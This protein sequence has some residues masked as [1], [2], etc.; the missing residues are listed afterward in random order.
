MATFKELEKNY[1]IIKPLKKAGLSLCLIF[2]KEDIKKF[3]LTY[4]CEIDLSNAE[5]SKSKDI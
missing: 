3:G 1:K 5:I 4:G 2:S